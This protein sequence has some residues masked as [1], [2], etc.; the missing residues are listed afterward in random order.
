[1]VGIGAY[2][3]LKASVRPLDFQGIDSTTVEACAASQPVLTPYKL[4]EIE[5]Y[6]LGLR[7][8]PSGLDYGV[9]HPGSLGARD[10][11]HS[12]RR[13]PRAHD[14]ILNLYPIYLCKSAIISSL[15]GLLSKYGRGPHL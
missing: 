14:V 6:K 7:Y 8:G 3:D 13:Q 2:R 12:S 5:R 15:E 4:L 11:C 9:G 1:M 10:K